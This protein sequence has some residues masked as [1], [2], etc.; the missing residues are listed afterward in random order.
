MKTTL[1][2]AII[3]LLLFASCQK[4]VDQ[5]YT[6]KFYG[7]A[8]EDIG[9]SV[10]IVSDGYVIAGQ[11]DVIKRSG[12]SIVSDSKDMGIIKTGW[13]GNVL[14]KVTAGGKYN[15]WGSK[16]NQLDDGSL[17]CVGTYTDTTTTTGTTNVFVVKM[18]ATGDIQWKKTYGGAGNQT[19]KDIVKTSDGYLILGSTDVAR[20]AP[21]DSLGNITGNTDILLLK[22]NDAG[23]STGSVIRG[24]IGNDVG[25]VIKPDLGGGFIVFGTTDNSDPGQSN[26]NL[27]LMK[28]NSSGYVTQTK[29]LGGTADE[30]AGDMEVL[31]DGYLLVYTIGKDGDN[32]QI[33]VMKLTNNIF[34]PPLF[35]NTITITNPATNETSAAVYALSKYKTNS[36]LLAGQSGKGTSAKMLIFEMDGSGNLVSGNQM[37]KGSTGAQVAYDVASGDDEYIIAVGKNSYD[38]NSMITFLKFKF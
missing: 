2:T 20:G 15:D 6:L 17:V 19:G 7:D 23:D 11:F 26:N 34:A 31:S 8:Y 9:Y 30:Y 10:T 21:G 16:I 13:D 22:I 25:K 5:Q 29:I 18:S 12:G 38:V 28:I 32:Q 24:Y 1:K 35:T 3:S 14:W 27:L 4:S 36:Y 37:I 33:S